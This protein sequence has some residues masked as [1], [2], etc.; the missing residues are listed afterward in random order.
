MRP[1]ERR[2]FL[3][4]LV[5]H[6]QT[7]NVCQACAETTRDLA[8]EVK[9]GSIPSREALTDTITAAETVLTDL[10]AVRAE[11]QRLKAAVAVG[12]PIG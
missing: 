2:E 10:R 6:E 9:R 5:A 7:V 12:P 4:I 8:A 3:K 11:L 1:D